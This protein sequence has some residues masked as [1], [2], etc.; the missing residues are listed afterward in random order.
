[1]IRPVR[2]A[3]IAALVVALGLPSGG[4]TVAAAGE[5]APDR[6]EGPERVTEG[7]PFGLCAPGDGIAWSWRGAGFRSAVRCLELPGLPP[8]RYEFRLTM[9]LENGNVRRW[10]HKITVEDADDAAA[11]CDASP[12]R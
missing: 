1:M 9:R 4:A 3:G 8:G 5:E 7:E 6:I 12:G 11:L 2:C 10:R